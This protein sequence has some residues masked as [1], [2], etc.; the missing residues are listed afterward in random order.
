MQLT[1]IN[2][3][4]TSAGLAYQI[5]RIVYA[6]TGAQTL[7]GVEAMTSM[8]KNLSDKSGIAI[9]QIIGDKNIFDALSPDSPRHERMRIF[10]NDR[11]F[12]M[13]LR[14]ARRMLRGGLGDTCYGATCFHY[15]DQMPD[16]ARARGYIAD[17][18]GMLFYL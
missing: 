12:Q 4:D 13:C 14:V 3:P 8:I 6:Q 7:T 11:A 1:L 10:A 2:N 9:E 17:V 18:D 15:A 5:A 16:W